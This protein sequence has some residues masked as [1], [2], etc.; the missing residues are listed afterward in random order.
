MSL[1]D[2]VHDGLHDADIV[3][4]VTSARDAVIYPRDLKPGSIVC[5][6]ARPRDVSKDV[7]RERDDVLVIEG[8]V[9]AVPGAHANFNFHFGFPPKTAY[10]C[11]SET[12]MLALDGRY[13]SFTLGKTVSPEQALETQR[14]AKKHG[15]ALAG[16]RS[17]E[18]AV[19][20]SDIEAIRH[21]AEKK[22]AGSPARRTPPLPQSV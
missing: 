7:A 1:H 8:G 16:Y 13:E 19:K 20:D 11:M 6:V 2:D 4:T 9:I 5:D 22:L 18:K 15:F 3:I 17:F 12:I 14:L 10:A 21:R